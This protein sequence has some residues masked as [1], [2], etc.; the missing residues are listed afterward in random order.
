MQ[1]RALVLALALT[2]P[3]ILYGIPYAYAATTSSSY[4]LWTTTSMAVNA[5]TELVASCNSGDYAV[6]GGYDLSGFGVIGVSV[7]NSQ[8]IPTAVLGEKPTGWDVRAFNPSTSLTPSLRTFVV[9]Q[10]P[11]TVAGI[12]VPE[13]GSLYVAIALGAAVYFMMSRRYARRPSPISASLA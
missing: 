6:G 13:F 8:P 7:F 5:N 4:T 9:C 12:G 1:T 3:G 11:I 10:T 2:L